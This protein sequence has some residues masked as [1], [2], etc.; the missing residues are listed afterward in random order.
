MFGFLSSTLCDRFGCGYVMSMGGAFIGLGVLTSSFAPN[1]MTLFITYGVVVSIGTSCLFFSSLLVLPLYFN[2][3]LGL[4][5]GIV[6]A[7]SGVGG[8]AL[9]P[10][11][12]CLIKSYGLRTTFQTY[13]IIAL[14]PLLGGFLIQRRA[15]YNDPKQK[16]S[17]CFDR[18]LLSN[19]AFV[20]FTVAM[21]LILFVYYIPYVHLVSSLDIVALCSVCSV[22]YP[23]CLKANA[24]F[25]VILL[26]FC[27]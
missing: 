11:F 26:K 8:I 18:Q 2:R 19:K 16:R 21:S 24:A 9:S 14:L 6:S 20:L 12:G 4:A 25:I 17:S 23:D 22:K 3:K 13:A 7:G 15:H 1:V 5:N 10:L 27:E